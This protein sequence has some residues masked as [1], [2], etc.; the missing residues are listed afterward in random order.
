MAAATCVLADSSE[1]YTFESVSVL[2]Y[3][4]HER[5]DATINLI[6]G[7]GRSI[8][9]TPSN[10]RT[11]PGM[12]QI[13]LTIFRRLESTTRSSTSCCSKSCPEKC[14]PDGLEREPCQ[15]VS[16]LADSAWGHD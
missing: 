7:Y 12:I 4:G 2:S 13:K 16:Q 5:I 9:A 3:S 8:S 15:K 1:S 14:C 6:A 11:N 10:F